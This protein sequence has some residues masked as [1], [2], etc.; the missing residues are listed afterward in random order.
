M[1]KPSTV[2]AAMRDTSQQGLAIEAL[3]RITS[4]TE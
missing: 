1:T 3:E 4:E 2:A